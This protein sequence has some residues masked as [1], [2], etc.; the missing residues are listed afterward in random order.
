ML[1]ERGAELRSVTIHR[2]RSYSGVAGGKRPQ[3][4]LCRKSSRSVRK[5]SSTDG[6]QNSTWE[7]KEDVKIGNTET[8]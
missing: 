2:G 6:L 4:P 5:R 1:R 8:N 3:S 7:N